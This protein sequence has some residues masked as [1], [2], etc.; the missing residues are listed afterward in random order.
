MIFDGK[1]SIDMPPP[2][3]HFSENVCDL[4][5]WTNDLENVPVSCAPGND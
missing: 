3:V 1:L 2:K 4:D 5:L